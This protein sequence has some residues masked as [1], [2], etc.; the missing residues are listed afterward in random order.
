MHWQKKEKERKTKRKKI[1]KRNI[2][3]ENER[4]ILEVVA[5]M[6]AVCFLAHSFF[7]T[8]CSHFSPKLQKACKNREPFSR[9]NFIAF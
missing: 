9:S 5:K 7:R 3:R 8:F 4:E 1:A 2:Q 6:F